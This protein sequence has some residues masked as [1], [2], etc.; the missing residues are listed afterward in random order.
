MPTFAREALTAAG[1]PEVRPA[2][3]SRNN[4]NL[5]LFRCL[6]GFQQAPK[7]SP[8]VSEECFRAGWQDGFGDLTWSY[9]D[10]KPDFTGFA[11]R[12]NYSNITVSSSGGI[13]DFGF[14]ILDFG[15]WILDSGL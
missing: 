15:F 14:W 6:H 11:N 5:L 10:G 4:R 7:S 1:T 12:L 8:G 2:N 3:A 9:T 13:L